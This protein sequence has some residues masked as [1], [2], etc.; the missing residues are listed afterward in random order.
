MH[1]VPDPR[2]ANEVEYQVPARTLA[3]PIARQVLSTPFVLEND[4]AMAASG[5]EAHC[6]CR[7]LILK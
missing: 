1:I 2:S 7:I 3:N 6:L 5:N 4:P